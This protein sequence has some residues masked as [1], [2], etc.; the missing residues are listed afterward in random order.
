MRILNYDDALSNSLLENVLKNVNTFG[1]S[2][3][4][5]RKALL[6]LGLPEEDL[7][8]IVR[9]DLYNLVILF[10]EWLN[11]Q[12]QRDFDESLFKNLKVHEKIKYLLSLKFKVMH[13]Y[14]PAIIKGVHLFKNP[15]AFKESFVMLAESINQMW[16]KAGDRATDFNYYTKR[17]MLTLVYT[18]VFSLW[19]RPSIGIDD[20]DPLIDQALLSVYKLSQLKTNA[21]NAISNIREVLFKRR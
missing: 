15:R 2:E 6:E 18:R 19:L 9:G 17:L 14:K 3:E 16:Y 12:I 20:I 10:N 1:W 7:N 4:S 5:V 21:S 11:E 8:F 13:P